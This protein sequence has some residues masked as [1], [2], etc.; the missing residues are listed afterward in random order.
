MS[1]PSEK[2]PI[3]NPFRKD[4]PRY[5]GTECRCGNSQIPLGT[6]GAGADAQFDR[7]QNKKWLTMVTAWTGPRLMRD[8]EDGRIP[9]PGPDTSGFLPLRYA[10]PQ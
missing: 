9:A 6:K 8:N 5:P 4:C 7:A 1:C 10:R 2:P 3:L